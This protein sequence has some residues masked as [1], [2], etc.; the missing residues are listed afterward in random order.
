[1]RFFFSSETSGKAGWQI[2]EIE[3]KLEVALKQLEKND[4]GE[5][6]NCIAIIPHCYTKELQSDLKD[7]K[8]YNKKEKY[9]DI[10]LSIDYKKFTTAK[11]KDREILFI[12]HVLECIRIA[13]KKAGTGFQAEKLINDVMEALNKSF[14]NSGDRHGT[15]L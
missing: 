1:M 11:E 15:D 12:N 5:G 14:P 10:R 9:I 7:R 13:G 2:S 8:Y 6:I 4:Y 3:N